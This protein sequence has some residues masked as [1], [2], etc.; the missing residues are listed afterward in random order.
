MC[1]INKGNLFDS[2]ELTRSFSEDVAFESL[3]SRASTKFRGSITVAEAPKWD[4]DHSGRADS[5]CAQALPRLYFGQSKHCT[6]LE[7]KTLLAK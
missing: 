6:R 1:K 5:G 2:D 3:M 7:N 4:P